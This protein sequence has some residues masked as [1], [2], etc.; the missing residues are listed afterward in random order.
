VGEMDLRRFIEKYFTDESF[1]LL[2]MVIVVLVAAGLMTIGF[3]II[4][5]MLGINW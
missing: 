2:M 5:M 1:E 4:G 3:T